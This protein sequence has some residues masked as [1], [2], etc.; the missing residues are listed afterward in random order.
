[1]PSHLYTLRKINGTTMLKYKKYLKPG[2]NKINLG[3]GKQNQH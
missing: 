1:M 3:Y 2:V